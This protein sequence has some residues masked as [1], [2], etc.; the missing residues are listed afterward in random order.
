MAQKL[1]TAIQHGRKD[2]DNKWYIT[3]TDIPRVLP[4]LV[5]CA[6]A[7]LHN[8]YTKFYHAGSPFKMHKG[9]FAT[10]DK[11]SEEQLDFIIKNNGIETNYNLSKIAKIGEIISRYRTLYQ[12]TSSMT[13]D[14][15]N[16]RE[17]MFENT[18]NQ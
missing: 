6:I 5:G 12:L 14:L 15:D 4:K 10:L 13:T 18:H 3:P 8:N 16:L 2:K 9:M 17:D 7:Q 1:L 11:M